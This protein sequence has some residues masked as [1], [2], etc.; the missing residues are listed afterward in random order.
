[1]LADDPDNSSWVKFLLLSALQL[2]VDPKK[3]ARVKIQTLS[4]VGAYGTENLPV[5]Q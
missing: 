3:I 2:N 4:H 5:I 1:M